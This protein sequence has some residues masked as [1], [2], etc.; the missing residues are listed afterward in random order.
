MSPAASPPCCRASTSTPVT[1]ARSPASSPTRSARRSRSCAPRSTTS[2]PSTCPAEA[3]PYLERARE[4]SERLNSILVAMGAATRVEEAIGAAE[5]VDFDLVPLLTSAVAAYRGAFPERQFALEIPAPP[6]TVHGAP[7]LIVQMLD[8]LIDN[9]VDFSPPGATITVRLRL[10]AHA[11]LIEVDNPGSPLPP[12][13]RGTPVRVT[14]A[15]AQRAGQPAA[16]RP[17]PVH[18]APDRRV[19]RRRGPRLQPP[20]RSRRAPPGAP[21]PLK[22]APPSPRAAR[23]LRPLMSHLCLRPCL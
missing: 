14:V 10:E 15:V 23:R 20:G 21:R 12:A 11:A 1:C 2:N 8:K 3:R 22:G 5:R 19:P 9:G 4:G 17:G 6:V 13:R 16:L 18:R 7:D